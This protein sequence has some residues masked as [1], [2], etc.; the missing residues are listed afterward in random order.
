MK[1]RK[2]PLILAAILLIALAAFLFFG[3]SYLGWGFGP[4]LTDIEVGMTLEEVTCRI[5]EYRITN[6]E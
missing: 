3:F 1:R 6:P 2:L 4:Q 5:E